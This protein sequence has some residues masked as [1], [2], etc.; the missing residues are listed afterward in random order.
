MPRGLA[1]VDLCVMISAACTL[2]S[3][4]ETPCKIATFL[5]SCMQ[6]RPSGL[7]FPVYL[8]GTKPVKRL[9]L[10]LQGAHTRFTW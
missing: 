4:L 9:C 10:F 6:T 8:R 1:T 5:K 2:I 3:S 7:S